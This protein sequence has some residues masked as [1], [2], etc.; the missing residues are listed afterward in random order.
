MRFDRNL[1]FQYW[2]GYKKRQQGDLVETMSIIGCCWMLSKERYFEL[3]I[4]DER[5]GGWGQQGTEVACKTWLSGGKLICSKKTWFA[6]MFRTQGGDFGFPYPLS[7]KAVRKARNHSRSLFLDGKWEKAVHPLSWLIERFTPVPDWTTKKAIVYYT[8]NRLDPT[9]MQACQAQLKKADLPII[10]VSLEPMEF[11]QN[12]VVDATRG[13]ATMFKQILRGL[14]ACTAETVFLAEHDIL[15]H[16][17]HFD[18]DPPKADVFYY[19][20]HVWKVD[21]ESGRALHHLSNHTSQLCASRALLLK[22]YRKRVEMVDKNGYT[23][24]MGF[25]PGTHRRPERVDDYGCDTWMS[26]VANIDIRHKDNLT[27]TRWKREQF[28]NQQYTKGW[29][30]ADEVPGWGKTK[31]RM[32]A[33]FSGI[34]EDGG[35]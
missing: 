33:F 11:G 34:M 3:D 17:S 15:Y 31:G 29:T 6:H 1:K 26:E 16:P 27:P 25:E 7:G 24:R 8:D 10:S 12:I 9:I 30:E 13:P 32:N 28:R 2:G 20:Q 19:N 18:F 23:R 5:H 35:K 21:A 4:C 22:H 14:E